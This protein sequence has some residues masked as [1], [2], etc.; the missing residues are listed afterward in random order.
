MSA[1]DERLPDFGENKPREERIYYQSV[2]TR[3]SKES[4]MMEALST[5][6]ISYDVLLAIHFLST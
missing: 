1:G 2:S 6:N 3:A 4:K 5:F